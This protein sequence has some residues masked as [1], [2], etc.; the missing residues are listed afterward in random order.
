MLFESSMTVNFSQPGLLTKRLKLPHEFV[1]F[2]WYLSQ[3]SFSSFESE[4]LSTS[5]LDL[6]YLPGQSEPFIMRW[7][8]ISSKA[9][10]LEGCAAVSC[11]LV[12]SL[13]FFGVVIWQTSW[14]DSLSVGSRCVS[15]KHSEHYHRR[16][17]FLPDGLVFPEDSNDTVPVD[18]L[19]FQIRVTNL[20]PNSAN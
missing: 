6:F 17:A 14:G 10:G 16:W 20:T 1:Y 13:G 2:S 9:F 11:S 12:A 19:G 15:C 18:H 4:S 3:S 5:K 7:L 8:S